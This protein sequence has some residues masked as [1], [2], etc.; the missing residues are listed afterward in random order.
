MK[1]RTLAVD[2]LGVVVGGV[3]GTLVNSVAVSL[4]AG[5]PYVEL[6]TSWGKYVVAIATAA[7]FIWFYAKTPHT[8]AAIL[9]LVTGIL[10]PSVLAKGVFGAAAGW[11]VVFFLNAIFAVVA[12]LVYR[13]IHAALTRA[14]DLPATG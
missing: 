7:T 10:I 8:V 9:S 13:S 6:V 12:L 2:I 11:G 14:A 1:R 5:V 3:A 4:L